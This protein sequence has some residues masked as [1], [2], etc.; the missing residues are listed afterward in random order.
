[1]VVSKHLST[2]LEMYLK[3]QVSE[4]LYTVLSSNKEVH[5]FPYV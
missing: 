5:S 2:I 1:M 3:P 4:C